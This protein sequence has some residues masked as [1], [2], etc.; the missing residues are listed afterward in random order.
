MKVLLLGSSNDQIIPTEPIYLDDPI[1]AIKHK[2]LYALNIQVSY[3]EIYLFTI[4]HKPFHLHDIYQQITKTRDFTPELLGQLLLHFELDLATIES[5]PIKP[6]YDFNDIVFLENKPVKIPI[7]K[8]FSKYDDF[9]YCVNPYELIENP[10]FQSSKQNHILHLEGD[11]LLNYLG[12]GDTIYVCLAKDVLPPL[13]IINKQSEYIIEHYY[14]QLYLYGIRTIDDLQKQQKELIQKT[15]S[16]VN[17]ELMNYYNTIRPFYEL[18][19]HTTFI[20]HGI[21]SFSIIIASSSSSSSSSLSIPLDAIFKNIHVSKT[22]PF[23][24]YHPGN[25][26]ESMYRLYTENISTNGKKIP[27]LTQKQIL[28]LSREIGKKSCISLYIPG[29]VTLYMDIEKSGNIVIYILNELTVPISIDTLYTLIETTI[30]PIIETMNGFLEQTGYTLGSFNRSLV[31]FKQIKYMASCEIKKLNN[32]YI[33]CLG[34]IFDVYTKNL[35]DGIEMQYKRVENYRIMDAQTILISKLFTLYNGEEDVISKIVEQLESQHNM[36]RNEALKMVNVFIKNKREG[37]NDEKIENSGFP[38]RLYIEPHTNKL[39]IEMEDIL[40]VEYLNLIMIYVNSLFHMLQMDKKDIRKICVTTKPVISP[41]YYQPI[42][43]NGDTEG[44]EDDDDDDDDDEYIRPNEYEEGDEG[45]EDEEDEGNKDNDKDI[46]YQ[47]TPD[48]DEDEDMDIRPEEEENEDTDIRP[49]E[50]EDIDTDIRPEEDEDIDTD[51][52]ND[53]DIRPEE[54]ED[55]DMDN[56]IRP[57]ENE[58]EDMDNDIRSDEE[59]DEDTDIRPEEEDMD[60][61]NDLRPNEEDEDNIDNMY[62]DDEKEGSYNGYLEKKGGEPE[63]QEDAYIIKPDGK[64]LKNNDNYFYNQLL[65]REPT[66]FLREDKKKNVKAYAR[67]CPSNTKLQPV[68]VTDEEL[69]KMDPDAY[70]EVLRYGT[71]EKKYNY[72]CPRYWCFLTN[73]P[74]THEEVLSGKCGK[75]IGENDKVIK[76]GHYVYEFSHKDEHIDTNGN[77]IPHYPGF[78]KKDSHPDNKCIPCCFK[79]WDSKEQIERRKECLHNIEPT[80]KKQVNTNYVISVDT[81]PLEQN[82]FG[83]LPISVQHFLRINYQSYISNKHEFTIQPPNSPGCLIRYG[84][85]QK[86]GQSFLGCIA[87]IYAAVQNIPTPTLSDFKKILTNGKTITLD[88]FIRYHNGSL[89]SIFMPIY[90]H[91]VVDIDIYK[92]TVFYQSID[93]TNIVQ[94]EFLNDTI[95]SYENFMT[96]LMDDK[97]EIDHTYLWDMFIDANDLLIKGGVNLAIIEIPYNDITENIEIL[98]PTNSYMNPFY[99]ENKATVLLLKHDVFYEPIYLYSHKIEGED[100]Q[101]VNRLTKTFIPTEKSIKSVLKLIR[102]ISKQQCSPKSS[103]PKIYHFK[104]NIGLLELIQHVKKIGYTVDSQIMNYHNKI[105][106]ITTNTVFLP[107]LPS[108]AIKS[109]PIHYMDD[110]SIWKDYPTTVSTLREIHQ[111]SGGEIRCLP[112][113]KVI[114]D[115][116]IVGIL[117][118]TNQFVRINP[119]IINTPDDGL[120]PLENSDYILLDNTIARSTKGDSQR[121][122]GIMKIQLEE[123]FYIAFRTLLKKTLNETWNRTYNQQWI[124]IIE[125]ETMDYFQKRNTIEKKIRDILKDRVQFSE[126]EPSVLNSLTEIMYDCSKKN[127]IK[128]PYCISN[129]E[130]LILPTDNLITGK[131]NNI[132]YFTRLA[133]ELIRYKQIQ[134]F[135]FSTNVFLIDTNYKINSDEFILLHSLLGEEYFNNDLIPFNTNTYLNKMTHDIANPLISQP[136]SSQD[137]SLKDQEDILHMDNKNTYSDNACITGEDEMKGNNRSEWKMAFPTRTKEIEFTNTAICSFEILRYLLIS[138]GITGVMNIH[139]L[140]LEGYNVYLNDVYFN[141]IRY[142][143][144]NDGKT[145]LMKKCKTIDDFRHLLLSDDYYITDFDLWVFATHMK[146]NILLYSSTSLGNIQW[147][148]DEDITDWLLLYGKG[149]NEKYYYIRSPPQHKKYK[150]KIPGYYLINETFTLSS[151]KGKSMMFQEAFHGEDRYK[152]N[153][154]SLDSYI[155]ESNIKIAISKK[156][157]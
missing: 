41:I 69:T 52:D 39:K 128:K 114:D 106:G 155:K 54:N 63:N 46:F 64:K 17:K 10:L 103:L 43:I 97:V 44:Q 59:E 112:R 74:M 27:L 60:E 70:T 26:R 13:H 139:Q 126:Y 120:I 130:G 152:H 121:E 127:G 6:I 34:S 125:D 42:V 142:F 45:E 53:N 24:K 90:K 91:E 83:I 79:Q 102:I 9:L 148:S 115:I 76:P 37:L 77:Y 150:N 105:I 145:D 86:P 71:G 56:D 84:V 140:L 7:G 143:I 31:K 133:D 96:Y 66:L 123:Q 135:M 107:C 28:K 15:K 87:D 11:V 92:D 62:S 138:S 3:D 50:D 110:L 78:K 25:K 157:G 147:N 141:K 101:I 65:Q 2:I 146:I 117:T 144:G 33:H 104:Q 20:E 132:V 30:Q 93:L 95:L 137:I 49:E 72:I 80:K 82:R 154:R 40:S 119:P 98:C 129:G 73:K 47:I 1:Y 19:G 23:I 29:D 109:L 151:L 94:T 18:T 88:T 111:L 5:I 113:Y 149:V 12:D 108:G 131:S 134:L 136:Y 22:I 153:I 100:G 14:P 57:E 55:I 124:H 21:K 99:D 61:D 4:S 32:E 122:Q 58:D 68:I 51:M 35:N 118:E 8:R 38:S 48:E 67:I 156:K 75:I 36:N 89:V 16:I 116:M 81:Y 85:E